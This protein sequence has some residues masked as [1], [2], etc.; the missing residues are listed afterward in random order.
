MQMKDLVKPIDEQSDEELLAR[1]R[2]IRHNR[3]VIRPA[4]KTHAKNKAKKGAVTRINKLDDML[5]S[6]TPEQR[7]ELIAQLGGE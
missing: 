3:N 4:A 2:E 7:A 1:L 6:L 5:G